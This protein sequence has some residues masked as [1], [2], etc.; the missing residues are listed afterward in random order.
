M[1]LFVKI[2]HFNTIHNL[3][4]IINS[5]I[6]PLHQELIRKIINKFKNKNNITNNKFM[7]P[8]TL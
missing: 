2:F 5:N 4:Y 3:E 7:K 1:C 6:I 8:E